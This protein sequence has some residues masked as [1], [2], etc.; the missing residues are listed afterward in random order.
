MV[1]FNMY[2]IFVPFIKLYGCRFLY[3]FGLC[4]VR[5]KTVFLIL[6]HSSP[7]GVKQKKHKKRHEMLA[8]KPLLQK[9]GLK[10]WLSESFSEALTSKLWNKRK[11]ML[12][13]LTEMQ[14]NWIIFIYLWFYQKS[15]T[16]PS[17]GESC[18]IHRKNTCFFCFGQMFNGFLTSTFD[19]YWSL[20]LQFSC[21]T[22]RLTQG[23][24]LFIVACD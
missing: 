8:F 10:N 16:D 9:I 15:L 23:T 4:E 3:F 1:I 19:F 17:K 2:H 7:R 11:F 24:F 22:A 14:R 6:E 20:T 13:K 21:I 5:N 18:K 12:L